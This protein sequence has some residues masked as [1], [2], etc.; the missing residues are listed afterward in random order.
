MMWLRQVGLNHLN[1]PDAIQLP[2]THTAA[3]DAIRW[4]ELM[5]D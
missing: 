3:L 4:P 1:H 2:K 5:S